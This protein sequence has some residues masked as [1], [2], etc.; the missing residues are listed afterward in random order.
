MTHIVFESCTVLSKALSEGK[1]SRNILLK[2]NRFRKRSELPMISATL[3]GKYAVQCSPC[4]I[5]ARV[6]ASIPALLALNVNCID[7][8]LFFKVCDYTITM[9]KG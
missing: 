4:W 1:T 2:S 9:V 7:L 6:F 5:K 8:S 3:E